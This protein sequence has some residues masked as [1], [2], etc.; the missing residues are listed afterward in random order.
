MKK[1]LIILLLVIFAACSQQEQKNIIMPVDKRKQQD[2]AKEYINIFI[3]D[4]NISTKDNKG[5]DRLSILL[6]GADGCSACAAMTKALT[7]KGRLSS[8]VKE[9]YL[10]YYTNI[11]R[12]ESW[13]INGKTLSLAELKERFMIVGTPTTV[14]MYGDE[15]LLIYPGYIAQNR[16]LGTLQFFLDTSLYSLDKNVISER[17]KKYYKEKNI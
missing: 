5:K 2:T 11:S 6:F 16:M 12:K 17:L 1:I 4:D 9:N 13:N 7:E 14:I 15:I 3:S 8:F 10:P